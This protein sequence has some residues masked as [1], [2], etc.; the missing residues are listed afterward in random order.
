MKLSCSHAVNSDVSDLCRDVTSCEK[1]WKEAKKFGGET[2]AAWESRPEL[3]LE[4]CVMRTGP[5]LFR[6]PGLWSAQPALRHASTPLLY[7]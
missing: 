5:S 3:G 7:H 6:A 2:E 1:L 4:V